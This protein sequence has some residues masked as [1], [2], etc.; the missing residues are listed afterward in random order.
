MSKPAFSYEAMEDNAA[1]CIQA[2]F[3]GFRWRKKQH[4]GIRAVTKLQALQRGRFTRR[5]FAELRDFSREQESLQQATRRRQI[6][7]WHNEQE[8]YFLKHTNAADLERVRA[9]QRQHSA[10]IIQQTWR[11]V[12]QIP[13]VPKA[14]KEEAVSPN[15]R[16]YT[17]N[18]FGLASGVRGVPFSHWERDKECSKSA[19]HSNSLFLNGKVNASSVQKLPASIVNE[20]DFAV[21]RKTIQERIKRKAALEKAN[22][23]STQR[24]VATESG[25]PKVNR[26]RELYDQVVAMK[27]A[28]TQRFLR[29]ERGIRAS[30]ANN[31][32]R[33]AQCLQS[34][35]NRI[36]YLQAESPEDMT[37]SKENNQQN[38]DG[39]TKWEP[40]RQI[41]AWNHHRR[42]VCA[43]LDKR[44]WWQT[45]LAGDER[46]I[47]QVVV[48]KSP[49]EDENKVWVWPRSENN[50]KEHESDSKSSGAWPSTEIQRFLTGKISLNEQQ[51]QLTEPVSDVEASEWW[52]AHCTQSHLTTNGALLIEK[53]YSAEF[54][55]NV[56][57]DG[58]VFPACTPEM[59]AN[60][61]LYNLQQRSKRNARSTS[62][63][64]DTQQ[65][66]KSLVS[67]VQRRVHEMEAQVEANTQLALEMEQR[68]ERQ[69]VRITREQ[70]SAMTI[71]RYAR[72]MQGR[73]HAR[74][75]RA[76]FFVMV[77]GRA[78]RRGR[79]EE[80]GDQRAVLECQQC[81]ES[82]HFCPICWVHV[83]STRRRKSHVAI[84]MTSV[85][86]PIPVHELESTK[87][88][89][90][91]VPGS[92][93]RILKQEE[94][95][96]P[97]LRALPS[98]RKQN[99]PRSAETTAIKMVNVDMKTP[100]DYKQDD[101]RPS[102][103][104]STHSNTAPELAEACALARRV[105][106][107]VHEVSSTLATA[108]VVPVEA[109]VVTSIQS[110][111]NLSTQESP[112]I[113]FS[114]VE[115]DGAVMSEDDHCL[116]ER[117]S[118]EA[119]S[120]TAAETRSE[121]PPS[122]EIPS[123]SSGATSELKPEE[124][125]NDLVVQPSTLLPTEVVDP[126]KSVVN[127]VEH[128]AKSSP[129]AGEG[130]SGSE[131]VDNCVETA[132]ASSEDMFS[133]NNAAIPSD[134]L[135]P[136]VPVALPLNTHISTEI[137]LEL[138]IDQG[139]DTTET[140]T[141]VDNAPPS[142]KTNEQDTTAG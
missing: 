64:Q 105:R 126:D 98:P 42:A 71:Q 47:R 53:P 5:E 74:E 16:I 1:T 20:E 87:A 17:F 134:T 26:R 65:R 140:V 122:A 86:T 36:K 15:D 48:V 51:N 67:Q 93:T 66:I 22:N 97:T 61:D 114:T 58:D 18:P 68:Q 35:E 45:Q 138:N 119:S 82:V 56:T 38:H 46:D 29:Y 12:K 141:T 4:R 104:V 33:S 69:R 8:L 41:Q 88:P 103:A 37:P 59:V 121:A 101:I 43:V 92:K 21:R 40:T 107:E 85:V 39:S 136:T 49:W 83:H 72:G 89:I 118:V 28:T 84:P 11:A 6:R 10:K 77:R 111:R 19:P 80:C 142:G 60:R 9:F 2:S 137:T 79:C 7:I 81:E 32:L 95:S 130:N 54:S 34:C 102:K 116:D 108:K 139:S 135:T 55:D 133:V 110:P 113:D 128:A 112:E 131:H 62:L 94:N 125:P 90:L 3:R 24:S 27:R 99:T 73:K 109:T 63:E 123:L 14:I 50:Q 75:V 129:A 30:R 13:T 78:I 100:G 91:E 52:R 70:K 44:S 115:G 96:G 25:K 120:P 124:H 57:A 117:D 106:A 127:F 31:E 76:E 132:K 23:A